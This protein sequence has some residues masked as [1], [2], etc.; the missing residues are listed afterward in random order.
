MRDID[1]V[2]FVLFANAERLR[3]TDGVNRGRTVPTTGDRHSDGHPGLP[4][5]RL[6]FLRQEKGRRVATQMPC[7][8]PLGGAEGC[9]T[10]Q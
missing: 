2:N 9:I 7:E 8:L 10:T 3:A 6:H 1:R 5:W 4:G